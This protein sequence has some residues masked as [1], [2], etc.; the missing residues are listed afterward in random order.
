[1]PVVA[2]AHLVSNVFD[3][4]AVKQA[5]TRD[6]YGAGVVEL[7]KQDER[8]VVLCADLSESTRS[9]LFQKAFPK[10]YV[11]IGVAEQNLI[12]VG[13]GLA[14]VGKVPFMASYAAFS[15][16]RCWEQIRT[17]FGYNHLHGVVVGAHAGVSVGPD[18]ATHQAVEDI[19]TM[20]TIAG[21]T[22]LV[23]SDAVRAQQATLATV[24]EPHLWYLR[25]GRDKY[26]VFTT[27]QTPFQVGRAELFHAGDD[28]TI[29]ACGPMV[30]E[31]LLAAHELEQAGIGVDVLD[32]TTVKPLDVAT[33]VESVRKTNAV[34]TA[35]EASVLGGLGGAVA[36]ALGQHYPA[37]IEY[38]GMQ[39]RYG[40]SGSTPELFKAFHMTTGD[41]VAAVH[42]VLKRKR[43]AA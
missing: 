12:T 20:R 42:R 33:I 1:M 43:H 41:I 7:G 2:G 30:Y 26:P 22:V 38:I 23:P 11:Q 8:I 37:P 5:G 29:I 27:D 40:A 34:V 15:P 21:C 19:A 13:A 35:E 4:A 16:G 17:T 6:G 3:R 28:V 24:T 39:D 32:A 10:R 14:S 36:E 25:M 18:G 9:H 31:A